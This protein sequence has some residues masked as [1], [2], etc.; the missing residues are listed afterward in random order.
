LADTAVHRYVQNP[1]SFLYSF[2]LVPETA[3]QQEIYVYGLIYMAYGLLEQADIYQSIRYYERALGFIR[4]HDM[5]DPAYLDYVIKPLTNNYIRIDD[6]QK[7]IQLLKKTIDEIPHN[8]YARLAGFAGN[9]ATAYIFNGEHRK[10]EELLINTLKHPIPDLLK[11]FLCNILSSSL[12]ADYEQ[13]NHYNQLAI[14]AFAN[15]KLS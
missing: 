11:G 12:K 10:A 4:Q 8:D 5:R 7:A 13:S 2:Q 14:A 6:N 9:L 3:E 15:H 1:D